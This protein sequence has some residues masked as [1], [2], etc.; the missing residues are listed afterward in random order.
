MIIFFFKQISL[1]RRIFIRS[2][3]LIFFFSD[4]LFETISRIE[5]EQNLESI[6]YFCTTLKN[7]TV[8][9]ELICL[10]SEKKPFELL[11]KL[12]HHL[13]QVNSKWALFYIGMGF[14]FSS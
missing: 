11:K 14:V 5:I 7:L 2:F 4:L 1:V 13:L 8:N 6:G 10:I 12:L 9:N 3:R